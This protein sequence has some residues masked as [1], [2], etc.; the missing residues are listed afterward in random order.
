MHVSVQILGH[1]YTC[2]FDGSNFFHLHVLHKPELHC[3][4]T[5]L[6]FEHL[7]WLVIISLLNLLV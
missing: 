4:S 5:T 6:L 3:N 2:I 7:V 1:G